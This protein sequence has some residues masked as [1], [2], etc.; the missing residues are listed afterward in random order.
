M[1]H[2]KYLIFLFF[3]DNDSISAKSAT[4]R[5]SLNLGETFLLLKF[6]ITGLCSSSPSCSFTI[7]SDPAFYQRTYRPYLLLILLDIY[8]SYNS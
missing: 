2:N 8:H 3:E 1:T 5:L 4:Q 6:L 7:I